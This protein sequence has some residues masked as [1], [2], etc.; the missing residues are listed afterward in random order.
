MSTS[1]D[2]FTDLERRRVQL[3]DNL[4]ELTQLLHHWQTWE[5][6]YEGLKEE[7][8]ALSKEHTSDNLTRV[9]TEF[10]GSLLTENEINGLLVD[11][12]GHKRDR[13]QILGLLL[14]RIDYVQAN[15]KTSQKR[16]DAAEEKLAAVNWVIQPE[17]EDEEGLPISDI[18]EELD[19]DGNVISSS[20]VNPRQA[21]SEVLETLEKSGIKDLSDLERK[22]NETLRTENPDSLTST[23]QRD[24]LPHHT[25]P[26]TTPVPDQT[27]PP[28]HRNSSSKKTVAF[29]DE[30]VFDGEQSKEE[31]VAAMSQGLTPIVAVDESIEDA[32]LRREL[33][34]YSMNE[35]GSI[36]AEMNIDAP[37]EDDG[38]WE[39]DE[40]DD[41]YEEEEDEDE[42]EDQWGRTTNRM[43]DDDYVSQ[44]LELEKKLNAKSLTNIGP[45]PQSPP[46]TSS[47]SQANT[48]KTPLEQATASKGSDSAAKKK[49]GVR[50]AENLDVQEAPTSTTNKSKSSPLTTSIVERSS[51]TIVS[52]RDRKTR[53]SHSHASTD[54][55]GQG[56]PSRNS[57]GS[58]VKSSLS[59]T[60]GKIANG[61]LSGN[62]DLNLFRPNGATISRILDNDEQSPREVPTGPPVETHSKIVIE[63]APSATVQPPIEPDE[64][65]PALMQQQIATD[66][67]RL[68]NRMIQQNG[69]FVER[70][71][72]EDEEEAGTKP[73][74]SRFKAARLAKLA[75]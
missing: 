69:G 8:S 61:P 55:Q 32:A 65:D 43:M 33:L 47:L 36:V 39:E 5:A 50:F 67:H 63:R 29:A 58:G 23:I 53:S 51:P 6:E 34:Q 49:K 45:G 9:G 17:A 35:V 14:R 2:S 37:G 48:A 4:A 62:T 73:V 46:I 54:N 52:E 74:M 72:S 40:D 27:S 15:V 19:D 68:R 60:A 10:G 59:K 64:F 71:E 26:A 70:G 18:I 7:L 16:R 13:K 12:K 44:M 56:P 30:S 25:E 24:L 38:S 41:D 31:D 1:R 22:A 75:K 11:D 20:I 57:G 3:E 66:Y 21:A 28:H 42:Y